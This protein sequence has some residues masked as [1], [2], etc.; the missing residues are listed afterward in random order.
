MTAGAIAACVVA[1]WS[2]PA[3]AQPIG[4]P[5]P[6]QPTGAM[7]A[8]GA[9]NVGPTVYELPPPSEDPLWTPSPAYAAPPGPPMLAPPGPAIPVDDCGCG[10]PLGPLTGED[11][12]LYEQMMKAGCGPLEPCNPPAKLSEL[13]LGAEYVPFAMFEIDNARPKN[14]L[15]LRID[16]AYDWEFPDRAEYFY[17][18][19]GG[20]GVGPPLVDSYVNYQDYRL[21]NET[22]GD[23]I[24]AF[25]EI[26]IRSI[27]PDVNRN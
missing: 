5:A 18:K 11:E 13:G 14:Q 21:Y 4:P 24:S 20:T 3:F 27:D 12:H 1:S 16:A 8:M 17:A 7:G 22:G 6:I 26:P 15:R 19:S 10:V 23:K 25:V 9:P 2:S